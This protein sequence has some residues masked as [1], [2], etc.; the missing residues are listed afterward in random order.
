MIGTTRQATLI[1]WLAF[2]NGQL[3]LKFQ[4]TKQMKKKVRHC[5]KRPERGK[6]NASTPDIPVFYVVLSQ[7]DFETVI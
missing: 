1:D 2:K 4:N 6:S 5:G 3:L 7:R